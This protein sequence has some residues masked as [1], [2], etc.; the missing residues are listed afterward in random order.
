M[1]EFDALCLPPLRDYT[2][3][4]IKKIRNA[5]KVS[6]AVFAQFIN[7]K[8]FTVAAWEQGK[9]P[10][11]TAIKILGLVERKGLEVLR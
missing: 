2:P 8:K 7:V 5:N 9:K 6:Q 1:R 4:E 3:E 11:R 10:S